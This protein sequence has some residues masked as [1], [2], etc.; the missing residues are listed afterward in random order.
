[1]VFLCSTL[2]QLI[3]LSTSRNLDQGRRPELVG[4]GLIRSMGGWSAVLA[5]RRR[6]ERKVADQRILGDEEFVKQI[7]SGLDD[8]VKKNLSLSGQRIDIKALAQKVSE[9]YNV[10]IGELRSGSRRR[11]VVKARRAMSWIGTRE[12][13]YFG[14]D[15]ARYLG[16]TNSCVTR[17]IS[18]GKKQ[19][20][21][22]INLE[23]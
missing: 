15:V 21:D 10:S 1:M 5:S 17:M 9:R 3:N 14:A 8:L 12:L 4:R 7:I 20:I 6:G 19:D 2:N 23:L 22:D 11:A 13:G 18:A 16:V